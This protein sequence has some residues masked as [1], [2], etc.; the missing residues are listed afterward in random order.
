MAR[1]NVPIYKPLSAVRLDRELYLVDELGDFVHPDKD[2]DD[3]NRVFNVMRKQKSV[4]I[5]RVRDAV[6]SDATWLDIYGMIFGSGASNAMADDL[7]DKAAL[8]W[9]STWKDPKPS[10][11]HVDLGIPFSRCPRCR[12]LLKQCPGRMDDILGGRNLLWCSGRHVYGSGDRHQK[13]WEELEIVT[14]GGRKDSCYPFFHDLKPV[15]R[16]WVL[17]GAT[18]TWAMRT[19]SDKENA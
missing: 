2:E 9:W 16:I 1:N 13:Y 11:V 5:D 7:K 3:Y 14:T 6:G 15:G 19:R 17:Q 12:E 8:E 18:H 10:W 4:I